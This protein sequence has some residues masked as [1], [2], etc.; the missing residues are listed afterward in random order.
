MQIAHLINQLAEHSSNIVEMLAA[1][2]KLTIKHLWK[3]LISWFTC[4]PVNAD[5]FE[6]VKRCQIRLH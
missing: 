3:Q 6:S 5:E 4:I 2:A 1:N